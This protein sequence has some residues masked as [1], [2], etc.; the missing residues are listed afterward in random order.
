MNYLKII[1]DQLASGRNQRGRC[2]DVLVDGRALV[3]L[4]EHFKSADE[5]C[6]IEYG[7]K[8]RI[9]ELEKKL[10][11]SDDKLC[12]YRHQEATRKRFRL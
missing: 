7:S 10:R 11:L 4:I 12:G 1:E 2:K 9:K 8:K 5:K 3:L 6:R